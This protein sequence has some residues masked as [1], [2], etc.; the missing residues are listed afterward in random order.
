[1]L[2]DGEAEKSVVG[3]DE[4]YRVM[5][6]NHCDRHTTVVA[7]GGGVVGDLAG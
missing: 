4:I 6:E 1:M 3:L 5:L 7:L 2:R